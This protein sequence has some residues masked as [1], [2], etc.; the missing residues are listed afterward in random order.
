LGG[1]ADV[2]VQTRIDARIPDLDTIA[3]ERGRFDPLSEIPS[4]T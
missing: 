2:D 3:P 1:K 4:G